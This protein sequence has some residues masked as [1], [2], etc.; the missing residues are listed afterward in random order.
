MPVGPL[1]SDDSLLSSDWP[2]YLSFYMCVFIVYL[3]TLRLED[4]LQ[5]TLPP[6]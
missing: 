1:E 2:S 3:T 6:A 4:R 5:E